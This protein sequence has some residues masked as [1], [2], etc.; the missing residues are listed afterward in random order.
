MVQ[1][2]RCRFDTWCD[3]ATHVFHF[4]GDDIKC[5][6]RNKNYYD[7]WIAELTVSRYSMAY[8]LG[9]PRINDGIVNRCAVTIV[10]E[11]LKYF[12]DESERKGLLVFMYNT[13][14]SISK[15]KIQLDKC[16]EKP[17]ISKKYKEG[18]YARVICK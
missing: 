18:N 2:V 14:Q 17:Y 11:K 3:D 15:A 4:S 12:F 16:T 13:V 7:Q 10:K 1:R 6:N 5:G 9:L 8:L